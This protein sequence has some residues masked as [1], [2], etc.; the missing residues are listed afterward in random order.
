MNLIATWTSDQDYSI[1]LPNSVRW[2]DG[3]EATLAE[4]REHELDTYALGMNNAFC[5]EKLIFPGTIATVR[6]ESSVGD[7]V[8]RGPLA[9]PSALELFDEAASD[10]QIIAALA[11]FPIV[12]KTRILRNVIE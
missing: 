11:S 10:E 4:Y 3:S 6:F 12:Y 7:W 1:E 2:E 9:M 5:V 8:V